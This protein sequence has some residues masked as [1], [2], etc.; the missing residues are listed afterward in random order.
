MSSQFDSYCIPRQWGTEDYFDKTREYNEREEKELLELLELEIKY[1]ESE[2]KR[3]RKRQEEK[4]K[5]KEA[6][7]KAKEFDL[8]A[9]MATLPPLPQRK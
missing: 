2:E 5:I 3:N 6:R 9:F 8:L 7:Q 1:R 4:A